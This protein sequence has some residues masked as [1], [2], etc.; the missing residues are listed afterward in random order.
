MRQIKTD[1]GMNQIFDDPNVHLGVHEGPCYFCS[2]ILKHSADEMFEHIDEKHEE[3]ITASDPHSSKEDLG[4]EFLKFL[5]I[6]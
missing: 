3:I 5:V 6:G 4:K 2:Q 1:L